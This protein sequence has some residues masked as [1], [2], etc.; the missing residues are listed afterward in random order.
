MSPLFRPIKVPRLTKPFDFI[1]YA[2]GIKLHGVIYL[3]RITD[4]RM[5]GASTRSF[6]LFRKLC[7]TTTLKNVIITT[8]MWDKVTLAEGEARE[9]ELKSDARFFKPALDDGAKVARHDHTTLSAHAIIRDIFSNSPL[10]LQ[11]QHELVDEK[12]HLS[13]TGAGTELGQQL[14]KLKEW[15]SDQMREMKEELQQLMRQNDE[16]A[17]EELK[18][19]LLKSQERLARV[20]TDLQA[21][22]TRTPR[23]E[24]RR[25]FWW[26]ASH[27]LMS[28]MAMLRAFIQAQV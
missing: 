24:R 1:S 27:M 2:N 28:F 9:T 14:D 17:V 23:K 8:S 6:R 18:A 26:V 19:E 13:E 7:G 5:G 25:K 21:L 15:F 10:P 16:R 11:L 4:N 22:Y 20:Q 12:K 3:H